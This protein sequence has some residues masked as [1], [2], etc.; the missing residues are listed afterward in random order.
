M[1]RRRLERIENDWG[2]RCPSDLLQP[3]RGAST[4]YH[5]HELRRA[6]L[7]GLLRRSSP[8]LMLGGNP[9]GGNSYFAADGSDIPGLCLPRTIS[10]REDPKHCAAVP[11][12]CDRY[13]DG[14]TQSYNR[15]R[16]S[17]T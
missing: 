5:G 15:A 12:G 1:C 7:R 6:S 11:H 13:E 9:R 2:S 10:A 16:L 3:V 14:L 4:D 17:R 8:N